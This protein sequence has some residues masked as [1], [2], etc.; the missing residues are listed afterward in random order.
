M[1]KFY[2]V[3]ALVLL[4][5]AVNACDICATH[6]ALSSRESTHRASLSLYEQYAEYDAT[7]DS[8][9]AYKS[10]NLQL[11]WGYR[12]SDRWAVQITAPHVEHKLGDETESG[13]GDI[14]L[15]GV[16][17]I[18]NSVAAEKNAFV[19]VYAGIK[20]P[21]GDSSPLKDEK[22][23]EGEEHEHEHMDDEAE[24]EHHHAEG[25]DLALGSGSWDGIFGLR[26]L[27][28][29]GRWQGQADAQYLLRTEGDYDFQYGDE[30]TSRVGLRYYLVLNHRQGIAAG[31]DALREWS[32]DNQVLG[33][34]QSGTGKSAS[35]VGPAVDMTLGQHLSFSAAY[36]LAIEGENQGVHG[37]ADQRIRAS[38]A[39]LF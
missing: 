27:A 37:A 19:D 17:R 9:E 2:A 26:G 16:Y 24:G 6:V 29:N 31:V 18:G 20:M 23:A 15:L 21:T 14:S 32:D 35:Y 36:D 5:G 34:T 10:S 7:S 30:F 33:E 13:L 4:A 3:V 11:G 28:Q 12:F 39:W 38:L 8:E 1:K 25:H 22:D